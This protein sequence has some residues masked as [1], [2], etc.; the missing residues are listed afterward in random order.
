MLHRVVLIRRDVSEKPVF[1]HSVLR[2]LVT[3]NV[4]P[5]SPILVTL[6]METL[7]S[8][9]TSVLTEAIR[10]T[11]Q[12]TAFCIPQVYGVWEWNPTEIYSIVCKI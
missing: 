6:M 3:V 7:G 9:E 4:A 1:S 8:S 2:L 12:K 11:S 10:V 5:S